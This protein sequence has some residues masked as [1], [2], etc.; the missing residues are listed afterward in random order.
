MAYRDFKDLNRRTAVGK[1]LLNKAFNISKNP[2]YHRY[3]RDLLQ[4]FI[5][6]LIKKISVEQL[7]V[8]LCLTK[9]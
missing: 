7:K 8:K 5:D 2:K 6:F 3:Q 9:N 4:W 1:V